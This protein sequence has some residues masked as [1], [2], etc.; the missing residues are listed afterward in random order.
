LDSIAL[1]WRYCHQSGINQWLIPHFH[2]TIPLAHSSI[3]GLLGEVTFIKVNNFK[4]QMDLE[5]KDCLPPSSKDFIGFFFD[6]DFCGSFLMASWAMFY[7]TWY[8]IIIVLKNISIGQLFK[9]QHQCHPPPTTWWIIP[10][11]Q[12]QPR[13]IQRLEYYLPNPNDT[14]HIGKH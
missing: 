14:C 10:D 4:E 3:L 11:T 1:Q 2:F 7:G 5:W 8:S 6:F 9:H 12:W 13:R